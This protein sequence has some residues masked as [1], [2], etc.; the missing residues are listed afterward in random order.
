MLAHA[1]A[2][3]E[4]AS[5]SGGLA[6]PLVRRKTMQVAKEGHRLSW[7]DIA[8]SETRETIFSC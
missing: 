2:G 7:R 3:E 4:T 6:V 8:D 5:P 1:S